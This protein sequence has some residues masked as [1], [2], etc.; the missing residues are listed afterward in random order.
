MVWCGVLSLQISQEP[1]L[2]VETLLSFFFK[3]L[4]GHL[5]LFA[6]RLW[7]S[8]VGTESAMYALI[9]LTLIELKF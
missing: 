5:P 6:L 9:A 3:Y 1:R 2:E 4:S 8:Y 7:A